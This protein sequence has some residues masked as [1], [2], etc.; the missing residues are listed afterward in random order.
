MMKD[1]PHNTHEPARQL[2]KPV[3][4]N[5][6]KTEPDGYYAASDKKK[7]IGIRAAALVGACILA[8]ALTTWLMMTSPYLQSAAVKQALERASSGD[9]GLGTAINS[10]SE[11]LISSV[12]KTLNPSTVAITTQA[13]T[14]NR[15]YGASVEEGAGSGIII[16]KDGYILTNKH[17]VPTGTSQVRVVLADGREF[18]KVT[19]VGVDPF[20]DIAFLKIQDVNDLTPAKI[21]DSSSVEPGM[22]VLAIGNTLGEFR[23]S[24]T[25]GIISGIGRPIEAAD[26]SG[27]AERLEDLFQTDAAINPGNSGGPLANLK[28]EVIGINTAVAAQSQGVGFALPINHAKGMINSVLE[29]GKVV[30]PYLGVRYIMVTPK[31]AEQLNLQVKSGAYVSGGASGPAVV[32]GGSA[33][34]AGIREKDV[35]TKINGKELKETATLSSLLAQFS[36]GDRIELTV[37]RD[38][39]EQKLTVTLEAY[40]VL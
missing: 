31:I 28:G 11:G 36:V 20:N 21:G 1:A 14:V 35:I 13:T 5:N 8:S 38:G 23:N 29:K 26:G 19:V 16:S 3:E 30:K 6:T 24:V 2:P 4:S 18:D 9:R 39:K 40:P 25:S 33:D 34:K 15:F 17:V 32:A 10:T 37:I 12:F 27:S 22:S 7:P